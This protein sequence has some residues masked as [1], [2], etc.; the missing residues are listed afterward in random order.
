VTDTPSSRSLKLAASSDPSDRSAATGEPDSAGS[1]PPIARLSLLG[2]FEL[3]VDGESVE[4]PHTAQRLISFLALH[5]RVLMRVFVAGSLW[6]NASESQS[7][8][9]LRSLLCHVRGRA[10]VIHATSTHLSLAPEVEV[11]V[12]DCT[13]LVRRLGDRDAP[14]S[15]AELHA[16]CE[17]GELLPDWYDDW[18]I[19]ERERLRQRVLHALE[20]ACHRLTAACRHAEAIEAGLSAIAVE[21]LR[22]TGHAAVIGAH[23]AEGNLIEAS[24]QY[25]QLRDLLR[26]NLG[27]VPSAHVRMLLR[28]G[29]VV[30]A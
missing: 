13:E 2:G 7:C 1:R 28:N 27:T 24:R 18:L 14:P 22:E 29:H 21:P 15:P 30:A 26:E 20:T 12:A 25:E 6:G 9:S 19:V 16:L 3:R 10:P 4:L 8:S 17:A 5:P 23:L 11:D